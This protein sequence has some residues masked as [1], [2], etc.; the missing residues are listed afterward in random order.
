MTASAQT[1]PRDALLLGLRIA[2]SE[3]DS[4]HHD[5]ALRR[6]GPRRPGRRTSRRAPRAVLS[7]R[8][9]RPGS[10][11]PDVHRFQRHPRRRRSRQPRRSPEDRPHNHSRPS[12]GAA[13]L[14]GHRAHLTPSVYRAADNASGAARPRSALPPR[15]GIWRPSSPAS[16]GR[17]PDP[18][19]RPVVRLKNTRGERSRSRS[20]GRRR[21]R[22]RSV[23]RSRCCPTDPSSGG[24]RR[25]WAGVARLAST[26]PRSRAPATTEKSPH[27]PRA[28]GGGARH[29][30]GSRTRRRTFTGGPRCGEP[31]AGGAVKSPH[32]WADR[33]RGE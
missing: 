3:Q 26:L 10:Q 11:R 21:R 33:G 2:L 1:D 22:R 23:D 16:H 32:L 28:G 29:P 25:G 12:R 7:A 6:M 5:Q 15:C 17:P 31:S 20:S 13:H 27:L 24:R 18:A 4:Q 9:R 30:L 14:R 8:A 19:R